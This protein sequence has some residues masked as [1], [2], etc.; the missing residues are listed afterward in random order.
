MALRSI[1]LSCLRP[2]AELGTGV[3]VRGGLVSV[4]F[5]RQSCVREIPKRTFYCCGR[6]ERVELSPGVS[7]IG[8][9]AFCGCSALRRID[10][11][12]LAAEAVIAHA[13]FRESGLIE[14]QLPAKMRSIGH[15]AF[16][17]CDSLVSVR[18]LQEADVIGSEVFS[19]CGSLCQ[20]K[21]IMRLE[22]IGTRI[23]SDKVK[24]I[25]SWLAKG[26]RVVSTRLAGKKFGRFVISGE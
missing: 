20:L 18:L 17:D 22:L 14:I 1:D 12:C 24:E 6:L 8:K 25:E 11:S 19:R 7:R 2:G 26:A 5:E 4:T 13:A 3:F 15:H 9:L 10:L 23:P 16:A 21:G